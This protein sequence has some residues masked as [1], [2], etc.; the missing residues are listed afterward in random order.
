M[1]NF[2]FNPETESIGALSAAEWDA[3]LEDLGDWSNVDSSPNYIEVVA[4]PQRHI[5]LRV[6]ANGE[7]SGLYAGRQWI[8]GRIGDGVALVL[9][10]TFNLGSPYGVLA[11]RS[12]G[13]LRIWTFDSGTYLMRG[14][15]TG[16]GLTDSSEILFDYDD[17]TNTYTAYYLTTPSGNSL[18]FPSEAGNADGSLTFVDAT[19]ESRAGGTPGQPAPGLHKYNASAGRWFYVTGGDVYAA[20]NQSP[21]DITLSNDTIAEDAGANAVVG[22]V[23]VSDADVGDSHTIS[24]VAGAGDTDNALFNI[25][26]ANLRMTDPATAGD[27]TYSVRLQADD[28]ASTPYQESFTITVTAVTPAPVITGVNDDNVYHIGTDSQY[29]D[30]ADTTDVTSL[31][32]NGVQAFDAVDTATRVDLLN[33]NTVGAA[34]GTT[35]NA[36]ANNGQNSTTFLVTLDAPVGW[37]YVTF[38][39]AD[40]DEAGGASFWT[41]MQGG[42]Q[43]A[44]LLA[45]GNYITPGGVFGAEPGYALQ[46]FTYIY[47][48]QSAGYAAT[49]GSY[50]PPIATPPTLPADETVSVLEN[51]T[52]VGN[53]S[54]A[55]AGSAPITYTISGGADAADFTINSSTGALTFTSAPDYETK[56]QYIVEVTGTNA[57]GSDAQQ[58]TVNITNVLEQTITPPADDGKSYPFGSGG[59]AQSDVDFQAWLAEAS[60]TGTGLVNDSAA[61]SYPLTGATVITFTADDATAVTATYTPVEAANLPPVW[62]TIPTI[63]LVVGSSGQ[64]DLSAYASDPE[65]ASL[66]FSENTLPGVAG[67][68]AAGLVSGVDTSAVAVFNNNQ[69]TANDGDESTFSGLFTIEIV[70]A[71]SNRTSALIEPLVIDLIQDLVEKV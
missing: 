21:T 66:I 35:V 45:E 43:A 1:A 29:A 9:H 71:S 5:L 25:D 50:T 69:V 36:V 62:Q 53:T 2:V 37:T 58:I 57:Y 10:G 47:L 27:G 28:G 70:E 15:T 51:N 17:A 54:A 67:I 13:E 61:Q 34:L 65:G 60:S 7:E 30:L 3:I 31:T 55:T 14:T 18:L 52:S 39:Q 49:L 26:G 44:L 48:E 64:F 22:T 32:L 68:N 38:V 12:A 59:I 56:Q 63:R 6:D 33:L 23:T 24:L 11:D 42:D 41:G 8:A 16:A 4:N 19:Y 20:A 40:I 46:P